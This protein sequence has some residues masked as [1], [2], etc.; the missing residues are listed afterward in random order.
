MVS[1]PSLPHR[2]EG[3]YC[4]PEG[5]DLER[6]LC[7]TMY[8]SASCDKEKILFKAQQHPSIAILQQSFKSSLISLEDP[9]Y[10]VIPCLP[11]SPLPQPILCYFS[12]CSLF[13]ETSTALPPWHF[14]GATSTI[15]IHKLQVNCSCA[16]RGWLQE[17]KLCEMKNK[18]GDRGKVAGRESYCI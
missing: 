3:L 15:S 2:S 9:P 13:Q 11:R 14:W 10:P 12:D 5:C 16:R 1:G 17:Q 7:Q 8:I 6:C 18:S 4:S